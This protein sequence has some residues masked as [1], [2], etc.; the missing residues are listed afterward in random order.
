MISSRLQ[1]ETVSCILVKH[2]KTK[3]TPALWIFREQYITQMVST[4]LS[5]GESTAGKAEGD[6]D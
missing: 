5:P 4:P 3:Q 6:A 1:E 2:S